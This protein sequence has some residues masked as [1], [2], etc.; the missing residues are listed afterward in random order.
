MK[1]A[2]RRNKNLVIP[3]TAFIASLAVS[4]FGQTK[5]DSQTVKLEKRRVV[6]RGHL[7]GTKAIQQIVTWQTA[8]PSGGVLPYA[9]AHLAIETVGKNPQTLFQ[10]DG[11]DSQYHVNTIQLAD[12]DGDGIPEITSLW[13]AGVSVGATLRMIHWDHTGR[14]FLEVDTNNQMVGIHGYRIVGGTQR[15]SRKRIVVLTR[16]GNKSGW[17][18]VP[19][20]AYELRGGKIVPVKRVGGKK[21][22]DKENQGESGIEGESVIGPT[23]PHIRLNDPTPDVAPYQATLLIL[24]AKGDRE[25]RRLETGSDGRFRVALPPGEYL[26][27]PLGGQG[28]MGAR[29]SEQNITVRAGQFTKVRI[30]FDSGM[31]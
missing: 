29:A 3:L 8:N 23:R 9:K 11:G 10:T 22:M 17:P 21:N 4:V 31:R 6:A 18:P 12:L 13:W 20:N 5:S 19:S 28:K 7:N 24:T 1:R 26:V 15:T 25:V 14:G 2:A 27:R 16:T 30:N